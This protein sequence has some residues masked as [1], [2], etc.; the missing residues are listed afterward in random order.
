MATKANSDY[1]NSTRQ[2]EFQ[3]AIKALAALPRGSRVNGAGVCTHRG[4]GL[5]ATPAL[6]AARAKVAT[7]KHAGRKLF[8]DGKACYP[9]RREHLQRLAAQQGADNRLPRSAK[10]AAVPSLPM[11]GMSAAR[12]RIAARQLAARLLHQLQHGE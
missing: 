5:P 6:R 4:T 10:P 2:A 11:D 8:N 1:G 7:V 3:R 9:G 12:R